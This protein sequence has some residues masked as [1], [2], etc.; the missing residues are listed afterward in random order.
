MT[1]EA[2]RRDMAPVGVQIFAVSGRVRERGVGLA[3]AIKG[4]LFMYVHVVGPMD[5]SW[6]ASKTF[7]TAAKD[8]YDDERESMERDYRR[9]HVMLLPHAC[10]PDPSYAFI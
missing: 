8:F 1:A 6:N 3:V 4:G 7:E 5:W 10:D 2:A 9:T